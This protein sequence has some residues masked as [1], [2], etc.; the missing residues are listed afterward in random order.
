MARLVR[1]QI[2]PDPFTFVP[3]LATCL[4]SSNGLRPTSSVSS[5]REKTTNRSAL[6]HV[7]LP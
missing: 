4:G 1:L 2:G 3:A 6:E 7:C 5:G